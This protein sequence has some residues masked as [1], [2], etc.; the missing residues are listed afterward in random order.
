MRV[1]RVSGFLC[2]LYMCVM[3]IINVLR[4]GMNMYISHIRIM[5]MLQYHCW[6]TA[7]QPASFL[8][9]T[10]SV[11]SAKTQFYGRIQWIAKLEDGDNLRGLTCPKSKL[12]EPHLKALRCHFA[13]EQNNGRS[14]RQRIFKSKTNDC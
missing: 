1:F 9:T 2:Y 12:S 7:P 6:F 4:T 10:A 11:P 3:G 13:R 14:S 8:A 5:G